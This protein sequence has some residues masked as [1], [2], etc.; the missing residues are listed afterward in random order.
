MASLFKTMD[1]AHITL[2]DAARLLSLPR[3]VGVDP[4]DGV[5]ITAQNGRYGPYITK[6]G[7][8]HARQR[9]T[10]SSILLSS[11][12]LRCLQHRASSDDALHSRPPLREFGNDPVSSKPVLPKRASSAYMSPMGKPMP[13]SRKRPPRGNDTR[14]R[15]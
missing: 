14:T 7:K 15:L 12:P 13:A 11:K 9:R 8:S 2:P 10:D 5:A 4:A 6:Q 1:P 3:V